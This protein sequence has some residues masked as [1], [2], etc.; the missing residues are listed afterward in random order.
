MKKAQLN[1]A[2][3][4]DCDYC[5]EENFERSFIPEVD[6]EKLKELNEE[7]GNNEN[8]LLCSFPFEVQCYY[9]GEIYD[10]EAPCL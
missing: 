8:T 3:Q 10:T 2:W 4:W 6:P 5:G 1:I 9:C 7:C